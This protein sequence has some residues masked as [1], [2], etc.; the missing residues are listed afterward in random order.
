MVT[1]AFLLACSED[2]PPAPPTLDGMLTQVLREYDTMD[3]TEAAATLSELVSTEV[4]PVPE[5]V[6]LGA[7]EGA[8]VEGLTYSDEVDW[9]QVYGGARAMALDGPLGGY[10]ATV[11]REDQAAVAGEGYARWTRTL[12]EGAAADYL[13]G[14]PLTAEDWIEKEAPFGIVLP[15]PMRKQWATVGTPNGPAQIMRSVV[16]EAGWSDDGN[17]AVIVAFTVELW[18]PRAGGTTWF[19]GTWT[20]VATPL[21]DLATPEFLVGEILDAMGETMEGTEATVVGG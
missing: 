15:Y 16:Y 4:L 3:L 11:P 5:G 10:A 13:Q 18:L 7:I 21:G 8:D 14:A 20:Q 19:N 12:V 1:V 9:K 17:N 2:P 6:T